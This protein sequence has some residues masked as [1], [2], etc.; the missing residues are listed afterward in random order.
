MT[1]LIPVQAGRG[2]DSIVGMIDRT[3]ALSNA[4]GGYRTFGFLLDMGL[5][6]GGEVES[7]FLAVAG[8]EDLAVLVETVKEFRRR[9]THFGRGCG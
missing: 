2:L 5:M 8:E 1:Y 6:A 4:A 7:L 3:Y 9:L